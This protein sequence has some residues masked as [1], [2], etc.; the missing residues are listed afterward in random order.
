LE[1][2]YSINILLKNTIDNFIVLIYFTIGTISIS[3]HNNMVQLNP[4]KFCYN[5]PFKQSK[6]ITKF[7]LKLIYNIKKKQRLL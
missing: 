3:K 4:R 5:S 7:P 6:K 2:K 1:W